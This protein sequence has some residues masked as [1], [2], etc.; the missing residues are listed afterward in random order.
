MEK[1]TLTKIFTS[2]KNKN[3]EEFKTKKGQKFWKMGIKTDEYQDE[4]MSCLFFDQDKI[5]DWNEGD[6]VSIVIEENGGFKN[7]K[8]PTQFD[9]LFAMF[10]ELDQRVKRL[11]NP[12]TVSDTNVP[13]PTGENTGADQGPNFNGPVAGTNDD[14]EPSDIPW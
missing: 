1:V 2:D 5:P 12:P 3:G 8:V 9:T 4:W 6:Q 13:Y 14:L 10:N 7:F 11:E